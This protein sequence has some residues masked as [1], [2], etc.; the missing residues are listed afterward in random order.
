M[1]NFTC[2]SLSTR[3]MTVIPSVCLVVFLSGCKDLTGSPGLP[4]GTPNPSSYNTPAGAV[5]MRNAAIFQVVNAVPQYLIESGL[6]T[7]ELEDPETG[8][9]H[10]LQLQ[11]G[12]ALVDPLDERIL[13][14]GTTGGI[15]SYN[16]L[17]TIREFANQA[18]GA[19]A[20]YDTAAARADSV[21]ILRGELYAMKGYGE[22]LLADLFC[23]GVPLSTLD[24]QG[25]FTYAASSTTQQVYL[26]AIAQLDTALTLASA[27]DS[28]KNLALVLKGRAYLDVGNALAAVDDVT[29]VP[30]TFQYGTQITFSG[31]SKNVTANEFSI[32]ATVS[33]TEGHNGLPYRS[34][35]DAR[36]ASVA[37]TVNSVTGDSLYF[38]QKYLAA[39]SGS[40][41]A[42]FLLASGI[43]AR[44]IQ[45]EAALQTA[46]NSGAWLAILNAL[47]ANAAINTHGVIPALP[48]T[49]TDPGAT[50]T[51]NA[52]IV[53]RVALLFRERAYWLFLDG[54]RQGDLRRLIR[55]YGPIG[56]TQDHVYPVGPYNGP[57]VG[58]YG[59]S[60]VVPIPVAEDANPH[61]HGC[62]NNA[63]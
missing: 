38:P 32:T 3:W 4:A 14:V 31:E 47:R 49:L 43:E 52:Q 5:G 58:A 15:S 63:A 62:L 33:D 44:L 40:G 57:G 29:T 1:K 25:D 46:P 35:G 24:F 9:S 26:A 22:I 30:D 23:S 34:S 28:V 10:G 18:I 54:H 8:I 19:L 12:Q 60:I 37:V 59:T 48:N 11:N 42:P 2:R 17:Q 20:T 7:D 39:L 53:A 45:A 36:T 56:L 27:S 41:Y 13:T 6:L 50:L 61:F 21:K 55:Q 16:K 51:G